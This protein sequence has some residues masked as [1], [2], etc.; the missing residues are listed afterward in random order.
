MEKEERADAARQ[1]REEQRLQRDLEKAQVDEDRYAKL[2]QNAKAEAASI[3][4]DRLD[5]FQNQIQLLERDLAE[6]HAR[7]ERAK[8]LAERTRTGWVYIISNIG[9]FGDGVVKIGLTRRLDPLD[10]IRELGDASVPFRFDV[11]AIIYSE[12][13]PALESALH[14]VFEAVRINTQNLRKEFFQADLSDVERAVGELAPEASFFKD[15]EAQ[16]YRETIARRSKQFEYAAEVKE[17]YP[18]EI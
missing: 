7:A 9:S 1:A 10:R 8:A 14:G 16:E 3:V 2:L 11:H 5:A 17:E 13:A 6:A 18:T 15:V 4:G 12:D